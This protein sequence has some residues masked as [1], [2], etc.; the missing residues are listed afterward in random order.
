MIYIVNFP[1]CNFHSIQRYFLANNLEFCILEPDTAFNRD[2]FVVLPG[3]GTFKEGSLYLQ[4]T[5]LYDSIKKHS[6]AGGFLLGICLGMQLLL[7]SSDESLGFHGLNIFPGN[8]LRIPSTP[9]FRVPHIGWNSLSIQNLHPILP[10][11]SDSRTLPSDFYFVHS[12]YCNPS[13]SSTIVA[14]F[15]HPLGDIPAIISYQNT[16]GIQFHPEKSGNAGYKLLDS[17]FSL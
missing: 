16:V 3:V 11:S 17:F 12:Y 4:Q 6:L 2:D 5:G 15:S 8:C 13:N 7:S 10:C 9:N 1:F 14:S